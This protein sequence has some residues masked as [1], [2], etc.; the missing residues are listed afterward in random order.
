MA[1]AARSLAVSALAN[2]PGAFSILV[3]G[4]ILVAVGGPLAGQT[5]SPSTFID[6]S[7]DDSARVAFLAAHGR[8]VRRPGII[9]WTPD[10]SLDRGWV[11]AF[12]DSLGRAVGRLRS[13][14]GTHPWQRLPAS[15]SERPSGWGARTHRT[16]G[17]RSG[18][19]SASAGS[20]SSSSSARASRTTPTTARFCPSRPASPMRSSCDSR[21]PAVR[22]RRRA[23]HRGVPRAGDAAGNDAGFLAE[24]TLRAVETTEFPRSGQCRPWR[25]R[26]FCAADDA[27][28]RDDGV[29]AQRT[30][31]GVETT[32]FSPSQRCT[33][34]R[35]RISSVA[36]DAGREGGGVVAER[37]MRPA[38]ATEEPRSGRCRRR[39]RRIIRPANASI[40]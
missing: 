27:G 39:K 22:G 36:N 9:F 33:R 24:R 40:R 1:Y 8:A 29:L 25:R 18:P 17:H 5:P 35:R 30:M 20:G 19:R 12:A 31:Q 6:W 14:V 2:W 13:S 3:A 28:R 7:A 21:G 34:S 38:K 26:I 16:P 37:T 10:D 11:T 15:R 23:R 32:D 4:M